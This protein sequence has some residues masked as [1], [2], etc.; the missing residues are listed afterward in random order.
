SSEQD[1]KMSRPQDIYYDYEARQRYLRQ[2][3]RAPSRRSRTTW[4]PPPKAEDEAVSLAHEYKPGLPDIGGREARSRGSLDQQ[5]VILDVCSSS[6]GST[7]SVG[8]RNTEIRF[9]DRASIKSRSSDDSLGPQTPID[10]ES[11]NQDRRYVFIPQEGIEIPLTYDE[12]RVPVHEKRRQSQS[13]REQERGRQK[14]VPKIDTNLPRAHSSFDVPLRLERERSPYRQA[15]KTRETVASGEFLLSPEA[16]SPKNRQ[17]ESRHHPVEAARR[18]L[19]ESNQKTAEADIKP[20]NRP[21]KPSMVRHASAMAYPGEPKA[22]G[23]PQRP[24]VVKAGRP[25]DLALAHHIRPED[26]LQS[27]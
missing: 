15:P 10:S 1:Y 20:S 12:P 7:A 3:A 5:P 8:N 26:L 4:P 23:T 21:G 6:S 14:S 11:S 13:G 24:S 22:T 18:G 16:M 25:S 17:S 9:G 27:P 19:K 2:S